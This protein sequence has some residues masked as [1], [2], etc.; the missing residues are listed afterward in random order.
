MTQRQR[1]VLVQ[2][3]TEMSALKAGE[4]TDKI[5]EAKAKALLA[6]KKSK[7]VDK[8]EVSLN[9]LLKRFDRIK[10]EIKKKAAEGC[11]EHVDVHIYP[12]GTYRPTVRVDVRPNPD[13]CNKEAAKLTEERD[14]LERRT[15]SVIRAIELA[16]SEIEINKLLGS[17]DIKIEDVVNNNIDTLLK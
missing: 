15:Q 4:L 7:G 6:Y 5:A 2:M 14:H 11:S 13:V 17:L 3:V 12:L 8:V 9:D 16:G 1:K 10:E